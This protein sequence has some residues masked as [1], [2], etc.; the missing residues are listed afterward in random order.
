VFYYFGG[1]Y[2]LIGFREWYYDDWL[3]LEKSGYVFLVCVF[4]KEIDVVVVMQ[5]EIYCADHCYVVA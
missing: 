5:Q 2:E 1:L 3:V 4:T